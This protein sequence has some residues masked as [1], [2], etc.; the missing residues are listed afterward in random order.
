MAT[1]FIENHP[2]DE[3]Q[4]GQSA[5]VQ[6][7]LTEDDIT[8]FSKV[9]GDLN[10]THLD[11]EYARNSGA[12]EVTGHSLW[13]SSLISSLLAN[14]L[15]GPG[16]IYRSQNMQFHRPVVLDDTVI[17]RIRVKEK[18]EGHVVV[19]DCDVINQHGET[20]TTGI[21]EV[22]APTEKMSV[23]KVELP[24]I[25]VHDHDSYAK[26]IEV[27]GGLEPIPTA[28]MHPCDFNSLKGAVEAARDD[29][30][31]PILVGPE[32]RIRALADSHG[33][34]LSQCDIVDAIHSH[35][36]A[37]RAVELVH[38]GQAEILMKGSLHTDE[39][40]GAVLSSRTG[41]RT[42]RRVSHVFAMDVPTYEKLLLVTDAAVNIAPDLEAKRDICQN[43][44]D[45]AHTFEIAEPKVAI[46]SAVETVNPKIPSTL[47]AA[48]LCKMADRGQI[49]GGM[50]E[51]P[52]AMDNA[53]DLQAAKTKGITSPVAGQADVLVAPDLEAGNILAKQLTF[54]A[55]AEAAGIVLGARVPIILTSRAD[56]VRARR[57][58]A[59]A[60]VM[61]A[62]AMRAKLG[63]SLKQ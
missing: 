40:L 36:A 12:G 33:I 18:K 8:L 3:L 4:I 24:E 23:P 45:L 21:A 54:L 38:A 32:Q 2:Y 1:E 47:D 41:L 17:A 57:A 19:F 34:D 59:A 43:A 58:S 53:I 14:V 60:A 51:G 11:E 50:V 48:A 37:A 46:L 6:R 30:I 44:I 20:V 15:P 55:N 52:L 10:P 29:L 42:E 25:T 28:V 56:S 62:H 16:T 63:S 22:T 26:L 49:Q 61:H 9:S 35:A 39:V 27:A 5:E 13:N 7:T 31:V